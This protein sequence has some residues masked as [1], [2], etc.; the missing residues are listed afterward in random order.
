M[1]IL[2]LFSGT[3]SIG[4]AYPDDEVISIDNNDRFNPTHLISIFDFDYKQYDYFDYIHA[5]PPCNEYSINQASWYGRRRRVNGVLVLF[6]EDLHKIELDK[7][8]KLVLK[9]LEIIEYFK[10]KY[11]TI[12]NPYSNWR[13]SLKNRDIM[14]NIKYTIVDYCMYDYPLKKPTIFFNNFDL[15]LKRCDKTHKHMHW[16]NFKGGGGNPFERYIVPSSL[17]NHIRD[18]VKY[19]L[20]N[21][22]SQI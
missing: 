8:D 17:C 2:E 21:N 9:A 22:T 10:P 5:S 12:E 20:N 19:I 4:K 11:W 15:E 6:N 3:G 1:K 7:S 13:N 18:V 14:K 16:T